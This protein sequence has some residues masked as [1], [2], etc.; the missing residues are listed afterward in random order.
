[1]HP[2]P[3]IRSVMTPFPHSIDVEEPLEEARRMM[4]EHGIRHV[5]V[6]D[7]EAL[8]GLVSDRD[9]K[10][11]LGPYC[12]GTDAE[13]AP[14]VRHACVV[15]V[16]KAEMTTPLQWVV[17]EMARRRI[18][19]ALITKDGRLAGIFT[20]TDA[21]RCLAELLANSSDIPPHGDEVA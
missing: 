14:R 13:D 10:L 12:G 8:V 18:G 3:S 15:D 1:M 21:C 9:I 17:A 7:G 16:F 5:P 6:K 19:S 11:V 20:A 2:R 4:E